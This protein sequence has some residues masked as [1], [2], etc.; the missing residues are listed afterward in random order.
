MSGP[1]PSPKQVAGHSIGGRG[2]RWLGEEGW[3]AL[4][5]PAASAQ[6]QWLLPLRASSI[7]GVRP[8][9]SA[10]WQLGSSSGPASDPSLKR[11]GGPRRPFCN[12][13]HSSL[14]HAAP[15]RASWELEPEEWAGRPHTI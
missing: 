7:L 10:A 15:L 3:G 13:S 12:F 4:R 8:G 1:A 6:S 11:K 9:P 2:P 14:L 5:F